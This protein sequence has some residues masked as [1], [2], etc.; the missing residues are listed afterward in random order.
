LPSSDL[1]QDLSQLQETWLTEVNQSAPRAGLPAGSGHAAAGLVAGCGL[2]F[3][4]ATSSLFLISI[5]RTV[6]NPS[7]FCCQM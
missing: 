4:T 7:V 5:L 2:R 3:L 6:S 1:F